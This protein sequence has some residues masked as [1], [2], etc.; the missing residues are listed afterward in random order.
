MHSFVKLRVPIRAFQKCY[1][2]LH[3][4]CY[5]NFSEFKP[6]TPK[7]FN[8]GPVGG[9]TGSPSDLKP[10]GKDRVAYRGRVLGGNQRR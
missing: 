9:G 5:S 7:L 1:K 10:D 6:D 4:K 2:T 8:F 3:I